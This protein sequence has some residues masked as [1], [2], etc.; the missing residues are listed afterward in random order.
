M[1]LIH[2]IL[3]TLQTSLSKRILIVKTVNT[4]SIF[5]R[6]IECQSTTV[7]PHPNKRTM[8]ESG[9]T[10]IF[11]FD[12]LIVCGGIR[13][14]SFKKRSVGSSTRTRKFLLSPTLFFM[15]QSFISRLMSLRGFQY[16][17]VFIV[18]ERWLHR[19]SS[20]Q[21]SCRIS[22]D[23]TD[24]IELRDSVKRKGKV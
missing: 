10:Y 22:C 14:R 21:L 23:Y 3:A 5:P 6:V 16:Q 20:F 19:K 2:H 13:R 17:L 18:S 9:N 15:Y 11:R 4:K 7:I 8:P 12:W 24:E 1:K